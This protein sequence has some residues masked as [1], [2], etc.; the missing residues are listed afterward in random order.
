[1]AA[2]QKKKTLPGCGLQ[3]LALLPMLNWL[4]L[5]CLG[6]GWTGP[7]DL[8]CGMLYGMISFIF[9]SAAPW[10]WILG[11]VHYLISCSMLKMGQPEPGLHEPGKGK[12]KK[13]PAHKDEIRLADTTEPFIPVEIPGMPEIV[14]S[15]PGDNPEEQIPELGTVLVVPPRQTTVRTPVERFQRDILLYADREGVESPLIPFDDS[16]PTYESMNQGQRAWYFFWRSQV[17]SGS[18]PDTDVGYIWLHTFE[19]LSGS[20]WEEPQAGYDKLLDLWKSYRGRHPGL[21]ERM[22]LW[23]L[24]FAWQHG[25]PCLVPD[26]EGLCLPEETVLRDLMIDAYSGGKPLKLPFL[27]VDALCAYSLVG[28][29]FYKDEHQPL[30]EEAMPRVVALADAALLKKMNKSLLAVYGPARTRKQS[31]ILY[32]GALCPGAE[33]KVEISVRAYTSG[34]KLPAFINELVRFSENVLRGICGYRGR[35]RGVEL[36]PET[37]ALVE[38]FLRKEY[39]NAGKSEEPPKP[40]QKLELDFDNI[41]QLRAQSDEVRDALEVSENPDTPKAA[42][43]DLQAV[44]ELLKELS[45]E[46]NELM[47]LLRSYGWEVKYESHMEQTMGSINAKALRALACA[48]LVREGDMLIAEDDYRDELNHIHAMRMAKQIPEKQDA[49]RKGKYFD[50]E[51]LSEPMAELMEAL[52]EMQQQV[53]HI[54]LLGEDVQERLAAIAEEAMTMP[55]ILIDEINDIAAGILDDILIDGFGDVPC[56]LEQYAE[57][58][59]KAMI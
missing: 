35:L 55:E 48:L 20:G 54:V 27:L 18:Y 1:M 39:G 17:R 13:Q 11:M 52:S 34:Q 16:R 14:E 25:L 49:P 36:D 6:A 44:E 3:T 50:M 19:L 22:F 57:E 51:K 28:S 7:L 38:A 37:A 29:K 46:E 47:D 43:T 2:E 24:D 4:A 31:H 5:V 42:L 58:L 41:A 15:I 10:M 26:L 8:L 21:D 53:V 9:P 30:V 56:V 40:R 33:Q 23:T 45:A 32:S 59:K 12:E